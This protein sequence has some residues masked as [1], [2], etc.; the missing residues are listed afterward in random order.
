V[1]LDVFERIV[2]LTLGSGLAICEAAF[3]G[4]RPSTYTF[5]GAVLISSEV[6]RKVK[7]RG[8]KEAG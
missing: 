4:A 2:K 6:A 5:I 1:T 3:W 8:D 7:A